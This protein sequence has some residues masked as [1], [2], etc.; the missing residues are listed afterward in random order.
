MENEIQAKDVEEILGYINR[1]KDYE[2]DTQRRI[3]SSISLVWGILLIFAGIL[4]LLL[5]LNSSPMIASIPWFLVIIG[6][7]T[8]SI[9]IM[10]YFKAGYTTDAGKLSGDQSETAFNTVFKLMLIITLVTALILLNLAILNLDLL[11]PF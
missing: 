10:R 9:L 8:Y 6:G 11:I 7:I 1:I 5:Q 4:D 2:I 3:D